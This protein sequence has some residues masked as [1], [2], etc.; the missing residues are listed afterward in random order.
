MAKTAQHILIP[1]ILPALFSIVAALPVDLLGCRNRGLI[2]A[3]L[4]IASGMLGIVAAVKG[5]IGKVRGDAHSFLWI[6]S[7]L[8]FAIPAVFILLIAA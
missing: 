7:A 8:I 6:V 3:L 2:A 1:L 5:L 4:A